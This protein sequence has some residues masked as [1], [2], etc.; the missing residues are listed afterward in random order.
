MKFSVFVLGFLFL[1]EFSSA[2]YENCTIRLSVLE[3]ALYET[4]S[5]ERSLNE[6]FL[7]PGQETSRYIKV[8][9]KFLADDGSYDGCN[10]S[11]IW[12]IG[13][14]LLIQPPSVFRFTSL[15]FSHPANNL[16]EVTITLPS[17]CRLLAG[18]E[19]N[20]TCHQSEESKNLDILTQQVSTDEH[21]D[22]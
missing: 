5:N 7:P 19:E 14:F 8:T 3:R 12:A 16:T 9:Y 2:Q 13:G 4:D 18:E 11:Y 1:L 17:Q 15:L 6:A 10:I 22:V 20:C 21:C